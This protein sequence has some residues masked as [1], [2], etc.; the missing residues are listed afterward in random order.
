MRGAPVR[1][2][3]FLSAVAET[4]RSPP[5]VADF[6]AF[7]VGEEDDE[8]KSCDHDS[9]FD[10]SGPVMERLSPMPHVLQILT[11]ITGEYVKIRA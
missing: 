4:S 8:D 3:T 11:R 6:V 1:S 2:P 7:R 5:R 9:F 10:V